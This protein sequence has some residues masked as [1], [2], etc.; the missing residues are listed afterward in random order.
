MDQQMMKERVAAMLAEQIARTH[1]AIL[2][3]QDG[4]A[5]R[6]SPVVKVEFMKAATRLIRAQTAAVQALQR[7]EGRD[8]RPGRTSDSGEHPPKSKTNVP[9]VRDAETVHGS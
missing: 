3:L 8:A 5:R 7:L 9:G 4:L 2:G 1:T 6:T